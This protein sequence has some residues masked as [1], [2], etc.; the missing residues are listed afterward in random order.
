MFGGQAYDNF[1]I[2]IDAI[3]R[4]GTTDKDKV[5]DEIEKTS[6]FIGTGG[7]VNMSNKDHM[8][9]DMWSLRMIQVKNGRWVLAD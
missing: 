4:A 2:V 9:M 7:E 6:K 8:G 5:R 1:F 3:K